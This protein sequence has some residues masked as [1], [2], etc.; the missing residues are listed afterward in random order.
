MF[1]DLTLDDALAVDAHIKDLA[2]GD[3]PIAAA[4]AQMDFWDDNPGL[5]ERVHT[6]KAA[7]GLPARNPGPDAAMMT[8]KYLRNTANAT[9]DYVRGVQNPRRDPKQAAVAAAGKWRDKVQQA[10]QRDA[11]RRG[12]S[13]YDSA[14]AIQAAT[15]DG[16]AAYSAGIQKRST[17]IANAFQKLAPAL[18]SVSQTIQ[19][20]PQDTDAQ[21]EARMVANLRA[22]R[23]VGVR[24]RGG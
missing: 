10:I 5:Y 16:G 4:R 3:D 6:A 22:M 17:K 9:S 11:F 7:A 19:G 1:E 2:R 24:I 18:A 12:V 21:R 20:M 23:D 13:N 8:E 15:S 14:A